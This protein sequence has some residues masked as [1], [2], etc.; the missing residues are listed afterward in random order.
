MIDLKSS[1]VEVCHRPFHRVL[2]L[3]G[4]E[5]G[6]SQDVAERIVREAKLKHYAP[7]LMSMDC[8]DVKTLP[9]ES[10]VV[11]VTSTTGQGEEP[12]N[13]KSF[14]RFLLRRSL[15][16]TSL[17]NVSYCV[18]GLG[19][20]GYQKFN[21]TAK[22][23][24][25]RL[26]NLGARAIEPLGLGDDQHPLGYEAA[27]NP[28][29]QKVWKSMR[30]MFPLP[31]YLKELSDDEILKL[32]LPGSRFCVDVIETSENLEKSSEHS[33]HLMQGYWAF[34]LAVAAAD[35]HDAAASFSHS[36][37]RAHQSQRSTYHSGVICANRQLTSKEA[38]KQVHHLEFKPMDSSTSTSYDSGDVLGVLPH[39]LHPDDDHLTGLLKRMGFSPN[40]RVRIY[41]SA[42]PEKKNSFPVIPLKYLIAGGIDVNSASPRRYFF[43]VMSHFTASEYEKERLQYFASA[44]GA[45]DLYK[46][47]RRERR[48][49][50]EIFD[51]FPS[52]KPSLEWFLQVSPHLHPR[53]YSISSS[54]Y[55]TV[56]TR[57]THITVASVEWVTPMK[58]KRR[59]LCSS[60]L[61]SLTLGTKISYFVSKGSISLPPSDVPLILVGPGTGIAPFRSFVRTRLFQSQANDKGQ[62]GDVLLF[63]GCRN[64][65]HDYLY[66]EE[67]EELCKSGFF[68][69]SALGGLVVAFSRPTRN[70]KKKYVQNCILDEEK[71]V[72]SL[73]E[74]G[75]K[76]F[77][78]GAAEKMPSAV[79]EA[80]QKVVQSRGS[81]SE[82]ESLIYMTEMDTN[83]RYFVD[84]W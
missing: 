13:M 62:V 58:R 52:M 73:L 50:F 4:S 3:Y 32:P 24:F 84:A 36:A 43:E 16:E 75:A 68:A 65:L 67:W 34:R 56:E 31:S 47:N 21:I 71:R 82:K 15:S 57:A 53:L 61:S 8:Y 25:R 41:P 6:N 72:W 5:T 59:G 83:G 77:V 40:V 7:I 79:R 42:T 22:K 9:N 74:D 81:R 51:D 46:Y 78:A 23:L 28:W 60:W 19:D 20:S 45:V 1:D 37:Y 49:V 44:Q 14:W 30:Q 39:S 11:F 18:F 35:A 27:L 64:A 55:D 10:C 12:R 17:T 26:A 38:V 2:V 29:L 70:E 76:V 80:I 48:T 33:E 63:F 66:E 54:P 69:T